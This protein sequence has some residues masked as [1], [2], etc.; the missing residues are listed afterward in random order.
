MSPCLGIISFLTRAL[1]L[2]VALLPGSINLLS[3]KK[4]LR[5]SEVCFGF[6]FQKLQAIGHIA[7]K[8]LGLCRGEHH[9]RVYL[10]EENCIG[11]R[12]AET[13]R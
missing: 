1:K 10:V 7:L 12:E 2:E 5:K 4:N 6:W 3:N 9:G 8:F 11:H 13:Q